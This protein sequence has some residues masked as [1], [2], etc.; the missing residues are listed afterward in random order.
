M[1]IKY[2]TP[3]TKKE[4]TEIL[5]KEI[6]DTARRTLIFTPSQCIHTV[7]VQS[8]LG[9]KSWKVTFKTKSM[10]DKWDF[11]KLEYEG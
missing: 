9:H 4:L 5:E 10:C 1:S 11:V 8:W 3:R 7:E 2:L 6:I